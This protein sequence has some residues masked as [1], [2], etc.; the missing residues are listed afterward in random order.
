MKEMI[1]KEEFKKIE[2][3]AQT[4]MDEKD[5][6]HNMQHTYRVLSY[7]LQILEKE[8]YAN[9][10]VVVLASLLH[11]IARKE[12]GIDDKVKHA[13]AG[14]EKAEVFL[15]EMGVEKEIYTHVAACI[16]THSYKKGKDSPM[17]L[18]GKILFDA[19]KLDLTG[20]VGV[21]RALIFGN[22]I[23]EPM[24]KITKGK[25][26]LETKTLMKEYE[27]KLKNFH[28]IFFTSYG[29]TLALKNQTTMNGFF[30]QLQKEV[31]DNEEMMEEILLKNW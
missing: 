2:A 29:K 6:V 27:N 3:Y 12:E 14:S 5:S 22:Q 30:T 28:E 8:P 23:K 1:K 24:Y 7:A 9:K 15:K 20:A 18:E 4:Q 13:K 21:T 25:I 10:W 11:D 26:D 17:S 19:D 31:L 16:A